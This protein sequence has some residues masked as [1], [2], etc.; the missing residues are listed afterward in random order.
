VAHYH[1]V[2]VPQQR[3]KCLDCHSEIHHQLIREEHGQAEFLSSVMSN[4]TH[5]HP[6]HHREQLNLLRGVGGKSVPQSTPNLMFGSRTNCFGCHTEMASGEDA[7]DVVRATLNGCIAC[8][9]DRHSET[10]EKWKL[11]LELVQA[12][13]EQAYANARKSLDE[14]KN[15]PDEMRQKVTELLTGAKADLD[16]VKRGNGLHNVTYAM[17]VLDSVTQ[18]AQQATALLAEPGAP[19]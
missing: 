14:A 7:G 6:K 9:G 17:E 11:G 13:A 5:C 12:D 16:L 19:P 4:C 15:I 8:H 3:A 1:K 18:R 2:H 10:F